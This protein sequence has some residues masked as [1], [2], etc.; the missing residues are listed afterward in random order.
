MGDISIIARKLDNGKYEYGWSG[1]NGT[2]CSVGRN[3]VVFYDSPD[4]IEETCKRLGCLR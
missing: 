4:K 3:L 2:H 1:N